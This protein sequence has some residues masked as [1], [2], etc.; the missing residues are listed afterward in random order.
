ML[1]T[2]SG[3]GSRPRTEENGLELS[4]CIGEEI[5][6]HMVVLVDSTTDDMED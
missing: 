6:A 1:S 5:K 4:G 2:G 3:T